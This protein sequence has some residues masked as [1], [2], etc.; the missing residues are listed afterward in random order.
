MF[1]TVATLDIDG[2]EIWPAAELR[3]GGF[4]GGFTGIPKPITSFPITVSVDGQAN[5]AVAHN[6]FLSQRTD[7]PANRWLSITE[8]TG[9][10]GT[11]TIGLTSRAML[12]LGLLT[13]SDPVSVDQLIQIL[14]RV[15]LYVQRISDDAIQWVDLLR[16]S[17]AD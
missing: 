9:K 2:Y 6:A 17:L 15:H 16:A 5:G 3:S 7:E 4:T 8:A 12:D 14:N 11:W 10:S 1:A 13:A